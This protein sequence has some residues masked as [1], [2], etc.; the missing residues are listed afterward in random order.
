MGADTEVGAA[1][2]LADLRDG[3]ADA[4]RCREA[5]RAAGDENGWAECDLQVR[6]FRSQIAL[7]TG[8]HR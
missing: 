2:A 7:A 8:G 4:L 5:M 6:E 1:D 3:L